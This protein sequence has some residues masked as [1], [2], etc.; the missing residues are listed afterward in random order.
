M[1]GLPHPLQLLAFIL[2]ALL[3]PLFLV[4]H[5][6][7]ASIWAEA[8]VSLLLTLEQNQF[9]PSSPR[10]FHV[11]HG[12]VYIARDLSGVE[13]RLDTN[14]VFFQQGFRICPEQYRCPVPYGTRRGIITDAELNGRRAVLILDEAQDTGMLHSGIRLGLPHANPWFGIIFVI[15]LCHDPCMPPGNSTFH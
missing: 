2:P 12:L 7:L 14:Q 15:T 6:F 10:R 9:S 11:R 1:F 8:T 3:L 13:K 5:G 4:R